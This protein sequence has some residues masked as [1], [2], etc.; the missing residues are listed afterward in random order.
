MRPIDKIQEWMENELDL[1]TITGN[2]YE[3]NRTYWILVT[4]EDGPN[5]YSYNYGYQGTKGKWKTL[6]DKRNLTKHGLTKLLS[7]IKNDY[8]FN[9]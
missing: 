7:R 8:T 2:R 5:N 4:K 6:T 9:Q 3:N 1:N